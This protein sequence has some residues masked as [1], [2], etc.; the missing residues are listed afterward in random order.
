MPNTP[1][2]DE[3]KLPTQEEFA[4][5]VTRAN[6][7]ED[8]AVAELRRLLDDHDVL[9]R[10]FGDLGKHAQLALIRAIAN[11]DMLVQES[12]TRMADKLCREL[13][14]PSTTKL[15]EMAIERIVTAWLEMQFVATTYPMPTGASLAH[16]RFALRQ[17]ESAQRRYEAAIRSLALIRKFLPA[18]AAGS[19]EQPSTVE[20]AKREQEHFAAAFKQSNGHTG[21]GRNG[22]TT[23][24]AG[25]ADKLNGSKATDTELAPAQA[26]VPAVPVNR[27]RL[28]LP[29]DEHAPDRAPADRD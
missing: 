3:A 24:P 28:F 11:G 17:K 25:N 12:V 29:A 15:E 21:N 18:S 10:T 7:G 20:E 5:L 1:E 19:P 16:Q 6:T 27:V 8:D 22:S 4:A 23:L 26:T 14:G 2:S 13:M 9:W